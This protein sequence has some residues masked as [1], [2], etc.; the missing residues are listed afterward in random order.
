[1][2]RILQNHS[3]L[4]NLI[5]IN[6]ISGSRQGISILGMISDKSITKNKNIVFEAE[7]LTGKIKVLINKDKKEIYEKAEEIS[8]D[9][10]MGFKG[11]G[12]SE[13]FFANEIIFPE[14]VLPEKKKSP[15][16]EYALFIGDLHFGSKLFLK[17]NFLRFLDYLNGDLPNTPEVSKIKYLFLVGD[18]VTGVG[19][20]PNQEKDLKIKDMERH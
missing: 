12:N 7:D 17:R 11:S 9:S 2:K 1:M 15:E 8:L 19:N 5:S 6:K 16:E 13:I 20:Y 14:A 4:D 3:D 10:V 18:L